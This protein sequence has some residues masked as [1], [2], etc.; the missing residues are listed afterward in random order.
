MYFEGKN[1]YSLTDRIKLKTKIQK[2]KLLGLTLGVKHQ[3]REHPITDNLG[4]AMEGGRRR[5]S[6]DGINIVKS[7]SDLWPRSESPSVARHDWT[8]SSPGLLSWT[9]ANYWPWG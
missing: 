8:R 2:T 3:Y 1:I 4:F 7:E 6:L 5:P 9:P